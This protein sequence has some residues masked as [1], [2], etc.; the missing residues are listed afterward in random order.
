M[1]AAGLA[2]GAV[3]ASLRRG[4]A[5]EDESKEKEVKA[6]EDLMREHGVLR[7]ALLVYTTAAARLRSGNGNVPAD[8]LTQTAQLFRKFGEDYYERMLEEQHVFPALKAAKGPVEK[9]PDVLKEQHQ[10][11]RAITDYV[12]AVTRGGSIG[13]ANSKPLAEALDGLVLMYRHHAATED[14]V[15]FPAWKELVS[16]RQYDELS[17]RFEELEQQMFGKDGFTDA[18]ARI[19]KVEQA[20]GIADLAALTAPMPPKL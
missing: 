2:A 17:D 16:A 9:L 5:E 20:F 13:S 10:R 18:V 1:I 7:R 15:V 12:I 8:A 4:R 3:G 11:G 19:E 6:V 14:T